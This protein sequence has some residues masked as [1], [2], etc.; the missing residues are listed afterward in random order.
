MIKACFLANRDAKNRFIM[1]DYDEAV[2]KRGVK[3]WRKAGGDLMI[4]EYEEPYEKLKK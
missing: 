3:N 2:W 1:G 4:Q